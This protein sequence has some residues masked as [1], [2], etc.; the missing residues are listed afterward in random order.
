MSI[1][2]IK[3]GGKASKIRNEKCPLDLDIMTLVISKRAVSS[4][5]NKKVI[6]DLC[7]QVQKGAEPESS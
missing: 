7:L 2:E 6:Y 3:V 4:E 1:I 5:G